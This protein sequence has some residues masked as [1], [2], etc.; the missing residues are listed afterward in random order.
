MNVTGFG[1]LPGGRVGGKGG[2]RAEW[3]LT[4]GSWDGPRTHTDHRAQVKLSSQ[5]LSKFKCIFAD[6]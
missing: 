2:T 1:V 4:S 3:L 6:I 5:Q